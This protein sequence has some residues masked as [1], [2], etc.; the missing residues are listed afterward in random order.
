[1]AQLPARPGYEQNFAALE[2]VLQALQAPLTPERLVELTLDFLKSQFSYSLIWIALYDR[3]DQTLVGHGG[4]T[5]SGETSWLQQRFSLSPG[6]LL[7]QVLV[8]RRPINI[9]DLREEHRAGEW[10][11]MAHRLNIQGTL[12]H[13]VWFRD[14]GY[15]VVLLGSHRWGDSPRSDEKSRLSIILGALGIALHQIA[16]EAQQKRLKSP[17]EALLT[18]L[19][20]VSELTDLP[21][22]LEAVVQQSHLFAVPTR[23]SIYW[24]ESERRYF[25]RRVVNLPTSRA[26]ANRPAANPVVEVLVQEVQEFYQAMAMGQI[27]SVSEVQAAVHTTAPLRLMQQLKA[28]SLLAAPILCH[29]EL[30]GFL[31][32]EDAEP[33]VWRD[34]E[35][36]YVRAAAQVISLS[37]PLENMEQVIQQT[38]ADQALTSGLTRAICQASDWKVVLNRADEQLRQRLSV[39]RVFMLLY[40]ADTHQFSVCHQT[41]GKK[42]AKSP[43]RLRPLSEVDWQMLERSTGAIAIESLIDDLRLLAW[44]DVLLDLG[45][46]SLLV[47]STT[48]GQPLEGI[49]LVGHEAPR[50]W[51][52]AE[53]QLIQDVSQQLGVILHQWQLV[54]QSEQQQQVNQAVHQGLMV[55]QKTQNQERLEQAVLQGIMETLQVPLAALVTWSA[56]QSQGWIVTPPVVNP[57]FAIQPQARVNIGFDPLIQAALHRVRDGVPVDQYSGLVMLGHQ[58]LA[59]DTRS[60]LSG[61]AIGQV[62]AMALQTDPEYEPSGVV[63]V[64]DHADRLW[65][66][67]HLNALVTLINHFA[68]AHRSIRLTQLLKQ[69]WEGL[70]SL[71]WYK[72]RRFEEVYRV[73]AGCSHRLQELLGQPD[74]D[75]VIQQQRLVRQMQSVLAPIA[76][77]L[78]QETWQLQTLLESIPLATLLKRSLERVEPLTRQRQLW[79]QVHNQAN[80]SLTIDIGKIELVLYELLLSAC[81]RSRS[82]GRID[83]WCNSLDQKWIELSITDDG[84]I[85][86]RLLIDLNHRDH[87]DLLAP[88]TLNQLPGRHL[89]VCQAIIRQLGGQMEMFGLED[90][91]ILSRLTLPV[92]GVATPP[93]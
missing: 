72:Q 87:L 77:V 50:T 21:Q 25:W 16:V 79:T 75:T 22:R 83:I 78:K 9:P 5:P 88:S 63:L 36:H 3:S 66:E 71:N 48:L 68:W 73:Q 24:Y 15:G 46:R 84:V 49:L 32:L 67:L 52:E 64:A 85:D 20:Q 14:Q 31:A 55:I 37:A 18:L 45:L 35:K 2:E 70:E 28:R 90:G 13:P 30:Y 92:I 29:R 60:W 11:R 4:I 43:D 17:D 8:M 58:D 82:G 91:R 61:L 89:K 6:D 56:G 33:R 80:L 19:N 23:T 27:V 7:E 34:D 12:I 38:R 69:E 59:I 54:R 26:A 93:P 74:A 62:V 10:R 65:S 51:H 41:S 47:C 44:R 1:M 86:P 53:T 81:I 39:E 40:D 76:T 57:Q 42:L